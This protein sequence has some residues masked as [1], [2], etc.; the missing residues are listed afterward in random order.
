MTQRTFLLLLSV[1][2]I[3]LAVILVLFNWIDLFANHQALAWLGLGF[4]FFIT[5]GLYYLGSHLATS[6]QSNAFIG[7]VMGAILIKMVLSFLI[8]AV[9]YKFSQPE[10]KLFVLPF[11]FVYFVYTIFETFTLM[12]LSYLKAPGSYDSKHH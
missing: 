4:F 8:I 11:F 7:L 12:K 10:D 5:L 9:Y 2:T 1:I 6:S 3:S